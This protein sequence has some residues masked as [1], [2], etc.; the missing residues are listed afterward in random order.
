ML[1]RFTSLTSP[2][3]K[4]YYSTATTSEHM[5]E[6]LNKL[7]GLMKREKVD[8]YLVV[9]ED[10]HSSEYISRH[11]MRR[12]WISGFDGS[13]GTAVIKSEEAILFTDGRYHQQAG[14]QLSSDWSLMKVGLTGAFL[15]HSTSF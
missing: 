12:S 7:R 6:R 5:S 3:F 10:Y 4:R 9:S 11:D 13:A 1:R 8:A 15:L 2:A 14:K